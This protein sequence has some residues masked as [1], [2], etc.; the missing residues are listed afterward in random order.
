MSSHQ[1]WY[2]ARD[3]LYWLFSRSALAGVAE[4][5]RQRR[6]QIERG[7]TPQRD[8]AE[9]ADGKLMRMVAGGSAWTAAQIE[10]GTVGVAEVETGLAA[11]G[12]LAAA[13]ID[14]LEAEFGSGS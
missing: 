1:E 10:D 6:K 7:F 13:E 8:Q 9:H 4:I 14:R 11:M 5:I 3:D 2:E 12:A